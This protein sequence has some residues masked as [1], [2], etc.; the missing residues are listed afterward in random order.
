MKGLIFVA[1]MFVFL[2]LLTINDSIVQGNLTE[3]EKTVLIEQ[4]TA[5]ELA[6]IEKNKV[7]DE[8]NEELSAMDFS[9]TTPQ[10]FSAWVVVNTIENF[11]VRIFALIMF[12]ISVG[13]IVFRKTGKTN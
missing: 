4:A 8:M 6:E 13:L 12:F 2:A 10:N 11:Y 9:D 1:L 3:A 7:R 5:K